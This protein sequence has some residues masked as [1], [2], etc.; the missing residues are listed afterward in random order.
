MRVLIRFIF[1]FSVVVSSA[2]FATSKMVFAQLGCTVD[3]LPRN[4]TSQGQLAVRIDDTW[5]MFTQNGDGPVHIIEVDGFQDLCIAWEA[6]PYPGAHR[7]IVYVSTRYRDEQPLWLF[8]NSA[9]SGI[10]ILGKLL[11]DWNRTPDASGLDPDDTFRE[12]H[13][14]LPDDPFEVP[15]NSL[16]DWH[17]T[18][19]WLSNVRSYELVVSSTN[20]L[21]VLPYGSERLLRL[22][23]KRP[24]TSWVPF[25]TRTPSGQNELRV[26]VSYTGDLDNL[27]P[28]VYQ[29]VFQVR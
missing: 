14:S 11:G 1:V 18:S 10:P 19:A 7:Q 3:S 21:P 12:Y 2:P 24:F 9:G 28:Y 27:G 20:D 29:Y 15:W 8:R 4:E 23:A 22:A 5:E 13:R 16:T 17:N 25:T 6:P 26:A